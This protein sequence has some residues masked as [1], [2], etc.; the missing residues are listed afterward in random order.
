MDR[1]QKQ[2]NVKAVGKKRPAL[3]RALGDNDPPQT[4]EVR[5]R[6][7]SCAEIFKHD[8]W[9]ATARYETEDQRIVVKFNRQQSICGLPMGWLGCWLAGR[10][11]QMLE[12]LDDV[13]GVPKSCGD[14]IVSGT[15]CRTADGHDFVDGSPLKM[16]DVTNDRFLPKLAKLIEQMHQHDLAYVDL[17]KAENV[18]VGDDGNPYVF[19]FQ[20]S[21]YLPQRWLKSFLSI[22]QQSDRYHLSR[23]VGFY[24]PDQF[25]ELFPNGL[26]RPWWIRAH[27]CVAVPFRETRRKLLVL[28]GIRKGRGYA[29]TEHAPEVGKRTAPNA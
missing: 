21:A 25:D 23:L 16:G 15:V 14:I 8:S 13:D 1:T 18:L 10:E 26:Q 4:I 7:F 27:R 29:K 9:A 22:L 19:D 6:E 24:R 17:H 5:G 2:P 11:R 3:F 20:I 28:L 12:L